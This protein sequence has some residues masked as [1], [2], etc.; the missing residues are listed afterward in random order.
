MAVYGISIYGAELYGYT[1]PPQYRVDPFTAIPEDY[2]SIVISWTKP[3]G[4]IQAWRVV[5][6]MYGFPVDQDDGAVILDVTAGYPGDSFTDSSVVPGAYHYYGFYVCTNLSSDTW[7]RAATTGCLMLQNYGSGNEMMNLIPAFYID[8]S[9]STNQLEAD[10]TGNL[11]LTSFM[12]VFGWGMD[13]LRTQYDTYLNVNNPWKIPLNDLY[14]LAAQLGMNIN[15]DIHP[16]TLRK[17]VFNNAVINQQR[18]TVTGIEAELSALTGYFADITVG[19]NIMLNNDQSY[20]ADPVYL[21]WSPN[22]TYNLNE[23][24]SYGNYE[25]YCISTANYG[26]APTGTTSNNTWWHINSSVQDTTT[27]ANSLTGGI[28]TWEVVQ[29]ANINTTL[30]AGS[31]YELDGVSDPLN[32]SNYQ[33]NDIVA[34]VPNS[35]TTDLWLRSVSRTLSEVATSQ[36][37]DK[38]QVIA[39]GIPVPYLLPLT[40]AWNPATLYDLGDIVTYNNQPF[41]AIRASLNSTPPY[42]NPGNATQ[43]WTPLGFD[44]RFR[45]CISGYLN[46]G[47]STPIVPFVEWYDSGGNFISRV[48][49]RNPGTSVGLPNS[50]C[51]DS[52]VTGAGATLAVHTHT[53]DTQ[54][55]WTTQTGSF[56]I[57]PYNEGCVYPSNETTRSISTVNTGTVNCQVGLTFTTAPNAGWSTGLVLRYS[58]TNSYLRA[59]MTTLKQ[60]NGG[61]I[62]T[63][64][65]YSSAFLAGDRMMVQLN[66]N[67]I[68]V[69][70]NNVSVL[71]VTSSFNNTSTTFGIISETT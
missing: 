24:V 38:Y 46:A 29:A 32:S 48:F 43:D 50:V 27:L 34:K 60:N 1:I 35:T 71:T 45:F 28:S 55:T 59:D 69:L 14:N 26:N 52:F 41:K 4:T 6:N 67:N 5:K 66:G 9:S 3:S 51:F 70:K 42:S 39:D 8:A 44:Q 53:D 68:T 33:A 47:A 64:G 65:T 63:L 25:Y 16:Y 15:P 61:T 22:I 54:Y 31:I 58:A 57:S 13:Y 62:T 49:S 17:A 36:V 18:G 12:N 40:P 56:S 20:F 37:P 11:F 7:V 19:A 2:E 10:P 30:P 23:I 21:P